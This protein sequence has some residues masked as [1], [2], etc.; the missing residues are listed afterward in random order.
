MSAIA[1][2]H[3][4]HGRASRHPAPQPQ[5]G[6]RVEGEEGEDHGTHDQRPATPAAQCGLLPLRV[7]V[8]ALEVGHAMLP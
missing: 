7:V 3:A 6:D 8:Q 5:G 2:V 4:R 1:D